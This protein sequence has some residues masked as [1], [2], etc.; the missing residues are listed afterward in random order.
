MFPLNKGIDKDVRVA[1]LACLTI[2]GYRF[3][4]NYDDEWIL[5]FRLFVGSSMLLL[6]RMERGH[7]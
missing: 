5:M 2:F 7:H 6:L 3:T 4:N 1:S